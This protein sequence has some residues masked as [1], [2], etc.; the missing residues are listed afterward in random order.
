MEWFLGIPKL[1]CV[2]D[3]I[4]FE[5]FRE[6][7]MPGIHHPSSNERLLMWQWKHIDCSM[8]AGII[9][10]TN[11]RMH[12]DFG[13][14]LNNPSIPIVTNSNITFFSTLTSFLH[15]PNLPL[16]PNTSTPISKTWDPP[17]FVRVQIIIDMEEEL[18]HRKLSEEEVTADGR[19]EDEID[20]TEQP[21]SQPCISGYSRS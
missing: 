4:E 5:L 12:E 14:V 7:D 9:I 20:S 8:D 15:Y 13:S 3:I 21:V 16:L 18:R 6:Q 19:D 17:L 11:K 10:L 2:V 1:D